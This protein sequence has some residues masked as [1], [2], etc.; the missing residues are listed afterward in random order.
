MKCPTCEGDS[1]TVD[2]VWNPKYNEA[3]R[4]R[5]CKSCNLVFYSVEFEAVRN[6]RFMRDWFLHHREN[7]KRR[8]K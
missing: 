3:L 4:K 6:K 5:K 8:K 1:I 7:G 2:T